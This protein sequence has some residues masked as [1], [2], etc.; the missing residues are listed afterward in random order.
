MLLL[1]GDSDI[2]EYSPTPYVFS[3][4]IQ[5]NEFQTSHFIDWSYCKCVANFEKDMTTLLFLT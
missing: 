5:V 4:I 2:F 3:Q 1:P